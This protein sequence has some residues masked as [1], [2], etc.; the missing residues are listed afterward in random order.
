VPVFSAMTSSPRVE[1]VLSS[2]MGLAH[3]S[4]VLR[5][6]AVPF[7]RSEFAAIESSLPASQMGVFHLA[8]RGPLRHWKRTLGKK[9]LW[10]KKTGGQRLSSGYFFESDC[11]ERR[12]KRRPL[13]DVDEGLA[14]PK[15]KRH[16]SGSLRRQSF[17]SDEPPR[18]RQTESQ[19]LGSFQRRASSSS[20]QPTGEQTRKRH[21]DSDGRS[22]KGRR[23][24]P[25]DPPLRSDSAERHWGPRG[26]AP[27]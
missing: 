6:S 1:K 9:D 18:K 14:E 3:Y 8:R 16:I 5:D 25:P 22:T 19:V 2:S 10:Q 26:R 12:P 27:K 21:S 20:E 24:S 17:S 7:T 4:S 23:I 15:T 13:S 11:D